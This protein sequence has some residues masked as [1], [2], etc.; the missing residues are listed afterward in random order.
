MD[1]DRSAEIGH[2]QGEVSRLNGV[3][4]DLENTISTVTKLAER[5][6]RK[7]DKL[8]EGADRFHA[9]Y[10]RD[11]L[12][13][14]AYN[15]L[16]VAE[17]EWRR[18]FG[19][20]EDARDLAASI[21]DVVS[22]GHL[23]R[24]VLLDVAERLAIRT[25][26]YWLA[27]A[28]VAIAAWLDDNERQH[29]EALKHAL[30]LDHGKTALFMALVLRDQ[31]RDAVLQEWLGDYLS[32]L[33]PGNLPPHFQVV[34]D[35]VTGGALGSGFAPRL[36]Q[37]MDD[38]YTEAA[39]RHDV[40]ASSLTDWQQRLISLGARHQRQDFPLLATSPAWKALSARHRAN[41]AIEG[42]ARHFQS[43]F[44]IGAEVSGD[45][46]A[47]LASLLSDLARTP[48]PAEEKDRR[49][50]REAKAIT[51]TR[52]D[53]DAARSLVAAEEAGRTGTLNIVSMVSRA[54]FPTPANGQ[55]PD[56]TVTELLSIRFSGQ[57]I[58]TA[59]E[60]L[61]VGLPKVATVEVPIGEWECRFSCET[62]ADVTGPALR[63]QASEQAKKICEQIQ[64]KADRRQ[65]LLRRLRNWVCPGAL[66]LAA[67]LAGAAFFPGHGNGW[68][69]APVFPLAA[70]AIVGM[71]QLPKRVRR[72]TD[73]AE[74]DKRAITRQI[75]EVSDQ[76][77]DI[78]AKDRQS[79]SVTLPALGTFLRGL[80]HEKVIAATRPA[81]FEPLPRTR[82]FP[83]WTPRPP[84][85]YLALES[86]DDRQALDA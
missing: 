75:S 9:Q 6:D 63:R 86:P 76:L 16:T 8:Q 78:W 21:V 70:P 81:K 26:R 77:A 38:W 60:S 59:A 52:G 13:Q 35:G 27:Q 46:R 41:G 48:D 15:R 56:P 84:V 45:V 50:I 55:L 51:E 31:E 20:F 66:V 69:M 79:V 53:L 80:T 73:Q 64:K 82:E 7:V 34:I 44:Q 65:G 28:T 57:L 83:P 40:A 12:V 71:H 54:A 62:E 17:R 72:A 10:E 67:G 19:R 2:L 47:N 5:V 39:G 37:R 32:G 43:R 29:H 22:S 4:R 3:V 23:D 14:D 42:A 85:Q 1:N 49:A 18:K 11:R 30:A 74:D 58:A 36:V 25:P 24:G 33:Q 68:L 61:R